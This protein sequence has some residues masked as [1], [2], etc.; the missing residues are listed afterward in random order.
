MRW[1]LRSFLLYPSPRTHFW[2][3]HLPLFCIL[4]YY[5]VSISLPE[6]SF[7]WPADVVLACNQLFY[8]L[9]FFFLR[10]RRMS[11]PLS[12][13]LWAWRRK[14][15]KK[16]NDQTAPLAS[17]SLFWYFSY[18]FVSLNFRTLILESSTPTTYTCTVKVSYS[19]YFLKRSFSTLALPLLLCFSSR[20]YVFFGL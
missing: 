20:I 4:C 8:S 14:N 1:L 2:T 9:H 19:G 16:A 17:E 18:S 11:W 15:W 6:S 13:M 5:V 3:N 10:L 7:P 12:T